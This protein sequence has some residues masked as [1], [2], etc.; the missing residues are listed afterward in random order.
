MNFG[1]E[2]VIDLENKKTGRINRIKAEPSSP[3]DDNGADRKERVT[4]RSII[5]GKEGQREIKLV[6]KSLDRDVFIDIGVDEHPADKYIEFWQRLVDAG[7]PTLPSIRKISSN[8][9]AMKE[10]TAD[11]SRLYGKTRS[12][13]SQEESE[14]TDK[15]FINLDLTN[16]LK[17]AREIIDKANKASIVVP[18][19]DPFELLIHPDGTWEVIVLDLSQLVI[20][21]NPDVARAKNIWAQRNFEDFLLE[22]RFKI[23][24]G[25]LK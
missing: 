20:A 10:L 12:Y 3:M 11:G 23:M 22:I 13:Q 16:V 25:G 14:G 7:I 1:E 9:V 19:D 24:R 8:Q 18:G 4:A 5:N 15:F 2:Q 17:K 21:N 6:V